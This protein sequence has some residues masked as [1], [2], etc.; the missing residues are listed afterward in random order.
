VGVRRG[1]GR[2]TGTGRPDLAA[3]PSLAPVP[4]APER[5]AD[6]VREA[7]FQG[8]F[9]PG[10]PLPESLL[11]QALQVSRNTVREALRLL[12]GER[13]LTYEPHKGVSVRRLSAA[14]V[15][16]IYAGRRLLELSAVDALSGRPPPARAF[17]A[18]LAAADAA[19][20]AGDWP[21]VGTANLRFHAEIVALHG[22]GRLDAFFEGLMTELRLGFLA[23][24]D[25]AAFHDAY[26]ERNHEVARLL[27]GGEHAAAR[28]ALTTYLS[29]A[30]AAVVAAVRAQG[31]GAG[32][33][34][35]SPR[36]SV[37]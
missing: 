36:R 27:R 24:D 15:T 28:E 3:L 35:R 14:D 34:P 25:P 12:M 6:L 30:A 17:T 2:D 8:R 23:L 9:A 7:V 33:T 4:T 11:S 37:T 20:A 19:T 1:A 32:G 16:D 10:T 29:D 18:V 26:R 5:A 31:D 22:N 13:L 21:A